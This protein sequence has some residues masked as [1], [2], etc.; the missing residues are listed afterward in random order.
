MGVEFDFVVNGGGGVN[1]TAGTDL[2]AAVFSRKPTD[3]CVV[4]ERRC[5]EIRR[6]VFVGCRYGKAIVS[7]YYGF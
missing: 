3:K 7:Q 6:A 1:D 4:V 5:F 2:V